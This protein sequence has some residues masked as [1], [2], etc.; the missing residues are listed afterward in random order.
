M[1]DVNTTPK[2]SKI[3]TPVRTLTPDTLAWQHAG[4]N[5]Q[6]LI[7][8][9]TLLLQV[10]HPV[11]GAGVG[12]HSVFKKD[13]WGRL[14]RTT[15]WGLKLIYG[16]P[17][18][19]P[20]TG[21]ALRDLHRDIK[22]T[23]AN[24]RQYFALNREAYAWVHMTTYYT[25]VTVQKHFGETPFSGAEEEQLYQEWRQQ[26]RVLGILDEDMPQDA[27]EF[28]VYFNNMVH[29][30]LE[31]TDTA[32]YL[33]E[34]SLSKMKKPPTLNWLPNSLWRGFYG[35]ASDVAKLATVATLPQRLRDMFDLEWGYRQQLRFDVMKR[36]V[37]S[38]LPLIPAKYRY[39]PPAYR[40]LKGI[41]RQETISPLA[42]KG[43]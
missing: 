9:T 17:E 40:A 20:A 12:D 26:G 8:G 25:L 7:A 32:R 41:I 4:D 22:G 19:S 27:R 23:D 1:S 11:V 31:D 33:L 37:K 10:S 28:W 18:K 24:G 14:Q 16:G 13:P 35:S 5:L 15:E 38:S 30:R 39:L 43:A 36:M 3:K 6:L 34:V 21:K 2:I 42:P 29:Q